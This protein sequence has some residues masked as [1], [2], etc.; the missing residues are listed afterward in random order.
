MGIIDT[1]S[2]GFDLVR[3]KAWLILV[4]IVLDLGVWLA[5]RLSVSSLAGVLQQQLMAP[6]AA[7]PEVLGNVQEMRQFLDSF[8][9]GLNLLT[10]LTSS[11]LGVANLPVLTQASFF[12][13]RK[14][15]IEVQTGWGLMGLVV[16]LSLLGLFIGTFYMGLV[17]QQVR[18]GHTDLASLARRVP[19]YW[20][21]RLGVGALV[22]ATFAFLGAPTLTLVVLLGLL[23][24]GGALSSGMVSMVMA[25]GSFFILWVGIYLAF[26]PE[27]ILLGED[28]VLRAIWHSMS[29]VR[30][31][32]WST[33]GLLVL[34]NIIAMGL[35]LVWQSLAANP[36]GALVA[37]VGNAF[38]GTGLAAA[39]FI[40]YR[41]R[42]WA[43]KKAVEEWKGRA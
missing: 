12:G 17:A 1:L 41:D 7:N 15:V 21:R 24:R 40:F 43:W 18:D 9:G 29:V 3:K 37:I 27:A 36:A 5:P 23:S 6:A 14:T 35:A 20:L 39:V 19:R 25:L 4:P 16:G 32:F 8:F 2:A 31:S 26:V 13:W 42:F 30:F 22:A 11:Y 33:L 38:V 34:V 10:L 28:G